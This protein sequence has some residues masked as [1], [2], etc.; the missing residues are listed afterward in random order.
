[1]SALF[2]VEMAKHL[3]NWAYPLGERSFAK[4]SHHGDRSF[5]HR[6]RQ[7]PTAVGLALH[8][9]ASLRGYRQVKAAKQS[10]CRN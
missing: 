2:A 10:N 8:D 5:L 1:M 6:E 3:V 7:Q 9:H 4:E